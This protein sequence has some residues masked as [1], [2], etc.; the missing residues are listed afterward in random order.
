MFIQRKTSL[1]IWQIKKCITSELGQ[2]MNTQSEKRRTIGLSLSI[3]C[4]KKKKV[5]AYKN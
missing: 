3:K 2:N 5:E 1:A 4:V